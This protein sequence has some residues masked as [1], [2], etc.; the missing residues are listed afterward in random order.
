[1]S[2]E[3]Q[4]K[5]LNKFI[6]NARLND[7]PRYIDPAIQMFFN[8]P[9]SEINVEIFLTY[10]KKVDDE[11]ICDSLVENFVKKN[12]SKLDIE[13]VI[14]FLDK[15]VSTSEIKNSLV[16]Y[17]VDKNIEN[18]VIDYYFEKSFKLDFREVKSLIKKADNSELKE[19]LLNKISTDYINSI[20]KK[21]F[22]ENVS[23]FNHKQVNNLLEQID[24]LQ[25]KNEFFKKYQL[26]IPKNDKTFK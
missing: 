2:L 22:D 8:H 13:N 23:K 17:C 25:L 3:N 26:Q 11:N 24:D 19:K 7:C 14:Y 21:Y 4:I 5:Q 15:Y 18:L 9:V 12:V 10:L 16:K 20:L 6:K 1:M